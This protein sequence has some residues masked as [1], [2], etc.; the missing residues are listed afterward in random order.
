MIRRAYR[1]L[2]RATTTILRWLGV[3]ALLFFPALFYVGWQVVRALI[4]IVFKVIL[5]LWRLLIGRPRRHEPAAKPDEPDEG[6]ES[7]GASPWKV[8]LEFAGA[9]AG[10]AVFIAFVGGVLLW[11]RFNALGLPADEAV[12]VLPRQ[13][14]VTVGAGAIAPAI[15]FGAFAA[16]AIGLLAPLDSS[17]QP[18]YHLAW[19]LRILVLAEILILLGPSDLD[20]VPYVVVGSAVALIGALAVW[21]AATRLEGYRVVGWTLFAAIAIAGAVN[22]YIRTE[23]TPKMEPAAA[24]LEGGEG[25]AGF[26][27]G[28]TSDRVYLAPLTSGPREAL[29]VEVSALLELRREK[30]TR[31]AVRDLAT[32]RSDGAGRDEAVKLLTEL[33]GEP[34][35]PVEE[36]QAVTLADAYERFAPLVHLHVDDSYRPMNVDFFLDHSLLKWANGS[37]CDEKD[38][39]VAAGEDAPEEERDGAV[40]LEPGLLGK[41]SPNPR[42]S[43]YRHAIC[44]S[45]ARGRLSAFAHT[46]PF[47]TSSRARLGDVELP[48]EQGFYLDLTGSARDWKGFTVTD[49]GSRTSFTG[50][51]VYYQDSPDDL[52][53]GGEGK[54]LTYWFL[55]GNSVPPAPGLLR[56]RIAHEG[57]W[58]RVSVLLEPAS[59]KG[60]DLYEPVSV[61]FHFHNESVDVPWSDAELVGTHP[62]AY[63]AHGSHATYPVPG[64][65]ESVLRPGEHDLFT[66]RDVALACADCPQWE[67][68]KGATLKPVQLQSW[69]GFGGAWGR[70]DKNA[71]FT[72]PLG[73]SRYKLNDHETTA[74]VE[75]AEA[76]Q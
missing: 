48:L 57:D 40:D 72:G 15:L 54:R 10:L 71:G 5:A 73:P 68:W 38:E 34:D 26:Y 27:V 47:D 6:D 50:V 70:A 23:G 22:S 66:A 11:A 28:Q 21:G 69:Y 37:S 75:E 76:E 17:G 60:G 55:Y 30:V 42:T 53:D 58:E 35:G 4:R 29:G 39:A 7:G 44:D 67:T 46:R 12:A 20:V 61:R 1:K 52:P 45:N 32:L 63:S 64:T 19:I 16:F 51:P 74:E 49:T 36:P 41:S 2:A 62:V 18:R 59:G 65:F 9:A 3:F 13:I 31:L 56:E 33:R 25:V 24:L 14:L 8:V 43:A